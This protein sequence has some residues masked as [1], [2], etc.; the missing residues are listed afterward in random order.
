[1]KMLINNCFLNSPE[2]RVIYSTQQDYLFPATVT[3]LITAVT[4]G[5]IISVLYKLF[6]S[7][8][9]RPAVLE[10]VG[11]VPMAIDELGPNK[12]G[13]VRFHGEHWKAHSNHAV[14]PGQKVKIVARKGL[15]FI[16][17]HINQH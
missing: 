13:F 6:K 2:K 15:T 10:F 7:A 12:E 14:A 8:K 9:N 4:F 17:E 11:Q 3:L 1:M 16:V 5:L